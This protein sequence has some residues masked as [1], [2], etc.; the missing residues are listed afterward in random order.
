VEDPV[1]RT[2]IVVPL[3]VLAVGGAFVFGGR[4]TSAA[5]AADAPTATSGVVVDGLGKVTGTPDFVRV[6]LGVSLQRTDVSAAL[7]DANTLQARVLAALKKDGV[8]DKDLQT[9]DVSL[10][11]SYDGKGRRNGYQIS[12]TL[13]AKLAVAKAG[14]GITDAVTAGGSAGTLQGVSFDLDDNAALLDAARDAAYADAKAK[15]E[16]YAT[17]SGRHLG[18]LQLV[19]ESVTAPEVQRDLRAADKAAAPSPASAVPIS[20]G[21]QQ[22]SVS[23]TVRWALR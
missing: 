7:R 4:G 20:A 21:S 16:R 12:E 2:L 5:V 1:N 23:V 17:L 15:A 22:V 19:T 9:S 14:Q 11:P 8:A 6:T 13:T 10:Y 18:D 3:A